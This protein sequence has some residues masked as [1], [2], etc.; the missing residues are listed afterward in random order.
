MYIVFVQLGE[1][2]KNVLHMFMH[3]GA[4][5]NDLC[6]KASDSSASVVKNYETHY[7][8]PVEHVSTRTIPPT[9]PPSSSPPPPPPQLSLP[10]PSTPPQS[11]QQ[12]PSPSV[13]S[14]TR[15]IP[16]PP[17]PPPV[18]NEPYSVDFSTQPK[19]TEKVYPRLTV[20]PDMLKTVRLKPMSERLLKK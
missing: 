16:S 10:S 19:Q 18:T 20:T 7:E 8:Q 11:T 6:S 9:P 3:L 4:G 17:P 12:S 5:A 1:M 14:T 13:P 2:T 15:S